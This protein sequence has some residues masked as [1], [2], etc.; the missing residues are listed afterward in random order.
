MSKK[1]ILEKK[2]PAIKFH[3]TMVFGSLLHVN[4]SSATEFQKKTPENKIRSLLLNTFGRQE[5]TRFSFILWENI[6][7]TLLSL[8]T[9]QKL[10]PAY[11]NCESNF[12]L[13][14]SS[15][16]GTNSFTCLHRFFTTAVDELMPLK[17]DYPHSK[18]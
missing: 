4:W 8:V 15:I 1:Q 3:G 10:D 13:C 5:H 12:Y 6:N 11:I 7:P 18:S 2:T 17:E 9:K 14:H 16:W